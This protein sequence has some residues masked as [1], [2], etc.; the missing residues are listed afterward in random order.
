MKIAILQRIP[1]EFIGIVFLGA[2]IKKEGHECEVFISDIEREQMLEKVSNYTPD[3]IAFSLLSNDY[4]WF[5]NTIASVRQRFPDVSVIVGGV[6]TT[7]FPE[8]IE[9]SNVKAVFIGEAEETLEEF[10]R[11]YKDED[12]LKK[13]EGLW[14]KDKNGT[15]HKNELRPLNENLDN[16]PFPDRGIYYDKYEDLRNRPQKTFLATRGCLYNCS[17]CYSN[18]YKKLYKGKG[19]YYRQFSNKWIIQEIK[20]TKAKYD[21]ELVSFDDFGE[22]TVDPEKLIEFLKLYNKEIGLP[23]KCSL[24]AN[25]MTDDLGLAL[26]E[27]N[28]NTVV[29][30]IETGSERIR[31]EVFNKHIKD[32]QII[33]CARILK[34]Y[35]IKFGTYNMFGVPT[36]TLADAYK[37]IELNIKIGTDYPWSSL[38]TPYPKTGISDL[39]EKL[40]LI[41]EDFNPA[42]FPPSYFST[43]CLD[44]PDKHIYEN[45][46]KVLYFSVRYPVLFPLFKKLVH[47]KAPLFFKG[48]FSLLFILRFSKDK[49]CPF[50]KR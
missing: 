37:T 50:G 23:F 2:V 31:N 18:S 47:I 49:K 14:Y 16:L 32:S 36:E 10:L 3:I 21:L 38:L 27:A 42:D 35:G 28:V 48:L 26:K 13:I 19:K 11:K 15:I 6:H 25:M 20:E 44:L 30:G 43:S 46:Q 8:L 5:E 7:F 45:L 9:I 39:A 12:S 24:R 41:P 17:Y 4:R 29:F 22:L 33:D 40:K 34:K 1:Y